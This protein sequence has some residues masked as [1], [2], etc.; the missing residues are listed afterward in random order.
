MMRKKNWIGVKINNLLSPEGFSHA[1]RWFFLDIGQEIPGQIYPFL[2][3][4]RSSIIR[5]VHVSVCLSVGLS[6]G[7][8]V[9]PS[10]EIQS[11]EATDMK[12]GG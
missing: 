2:G 12:L 10:I 1:E 5:V 9:R 7:R 8:Y 11:F 4:A 6:V 3:S